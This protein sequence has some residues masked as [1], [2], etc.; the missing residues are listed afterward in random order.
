MAYDSTRQRT[1]LF[2]A[3]NPGNQPQTWEWD[4]VNWQRQTPVASPSGRAGFALAYDELRARTVLF[5]GRSSGVALGDTWEWDGVNWVQ[6]SSPGGPPP[7]FGH[8]M[9]YDAYF[10]R[11]IVLYGG[12]GVGSLWMDTWVWDGRWT[13]VY[14]NNTPRWRW[15][16]VMARGPSWSSVILYG[17]FDSTS[18]PLS[19]AYS[20]FDPQWAREDA[21][22]EIVNRPALSNDPARDGMLLHGAN[23]YGRST[24]WTFGISSLVKAYGTGCASSTVKPTLTAYGQARIGNAR[25]ALDVDGVRANAPVALLLSTARASLVFGGCPLLV[26]PTTLWMIAGTSNAFGAESFVLP[27]PLDRRIVGRIYAQAVGLDPMLPQFAVT[28][29]LE[30]SIGS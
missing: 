14:P 10:G 8:A 3:A 19:D 16:H 18:A 25:F 27:L 1:V 21:P 17:G 12:Q 20:W 11:R 24:T 13:L 28:H 29:G 5:G 23:P 15:G 9:A 2:G 30:I 7:R 26:D 6:R 22:A 4:G